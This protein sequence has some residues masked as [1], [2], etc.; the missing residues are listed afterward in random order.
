[1]CR[2][3][4]VMTASRSSVSRPGTGATKRATAS[5]VGRSDPGPSGRAGGDKSA[6]C[7]LTVVV[8]PHSSRE[9]VRLLGEFSADR[10]DRHLEVEVRVRA[11]PVDGAANSA[12]IHA[13][14][15]AL[16]IRPAAVTITR[17]SHSRTKHVSVALTAPEVRAA[18]AE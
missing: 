17:G 6:G 16:G 8:K 5:R 18:L 12:V 2:H 10:S 15:R 9:S 1:M 14:A 13:L 7:S 3:N 11:K 4:D